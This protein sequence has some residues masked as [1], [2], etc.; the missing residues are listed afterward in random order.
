MLYSIFCSLA[1]L[2]GYHLIFTQLDWGRGFWAQ[3]AQAVIFSGSAGLM[4][5]WGVV[6]VQ[7][8]CVAGITGGFVAWYHAWCVRS[9]AL[10]EAKY[11]TR[12]RAQ[13]EEL[14]ALQAK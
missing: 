10:E 5:S 11:Q 7:N 4:L 1:G 2:L 9:K 12:R 8:A 3:L 14:K 6:P 13:D